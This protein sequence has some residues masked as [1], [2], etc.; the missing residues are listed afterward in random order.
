MYI[1]YTLLSYVYIILFKALNALIDNQ[2]FLKEKWW[3]FAQNDIFYIFKINFKY[4]KYS[5]VYYQ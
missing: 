4:W 5:N 3:N 1:Y 2:S